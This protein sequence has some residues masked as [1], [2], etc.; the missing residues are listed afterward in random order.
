MRIS[1]RVFR[2]L[3]PLGGFGDISLPATVRFC[4]YRVLF[5]FFVYV[6]TSWD[7]LLYTP[8]DVQFRPRFGRTT[9]PAE[10]RNGLGKCIEV[11]ARET[12][13][14]FKIGSGCS[15]L[16]GVDLKCTSVFLCPAE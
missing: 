4:F 3:V 8:N 15:G 12:H 11:D 16:S 10:K 5:V 13:N 9:L 14:C 6:A 1:V 7:R 2:E